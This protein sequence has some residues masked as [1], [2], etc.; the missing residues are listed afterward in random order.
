MTFLSL[1]PIPGRNW[2]PGELES[3]RN[4]A[5]EAIE[6]YL[7]TSW[8]EL[9]D[10][11][12]LFNELFMEHMHHVRETGGASL[13]IHSETF[14]LTI[15]DQSANIQKVDEFLVSLGFVG[16]RTSTPTPTP[17]PQRRPIS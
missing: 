5:L 8:I 17:T 3:L 7:D 1:Q 2:K 14:I 10:S 12:E 6:S 4:R 9:D 13:G 15:A 11:N 16:R